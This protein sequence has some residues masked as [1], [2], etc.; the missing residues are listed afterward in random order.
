[1]AKIE[2]DNTQWHITTTEP[3]YWC[4]TDEQYLYSRGHLSCGET[5]TRHIGKVDISTDK[6]VIDSIC[7]SKELFIN[8]LI[9]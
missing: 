1:M 9:E 2:K 6:S 3:I 5:Y 8:D 7:N 4:T